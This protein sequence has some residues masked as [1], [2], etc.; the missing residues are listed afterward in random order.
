MMAHLKDMLEQHFNN[1]RRCKLIEHNHEH[2]TDEQFLDQLKQLREIEH[3]V[4]TL[5]KQSEDLLV[6]RE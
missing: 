3:S 2:I 4:Y 1:L 5:I 6:D